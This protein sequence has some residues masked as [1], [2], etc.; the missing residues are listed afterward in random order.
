MGCT[1]SRKSLVSAL[2]GGSDA[3][4][5]AREIKRAEGVRYRY[6]TAGF[7]AKYEILDSVMLRMGMLAA[8][9]ARLHPG[10]AIGIMVTASHN[11]ECDN[12]VKIADFDGG[13]LNPEWESLASTLANCSEEK[14]IATLST[15]ARDAG[16]SFEDS[17]ALVFVGE[18]TRASSPHLASLV[19]KGAGV[20]GATVKRY[21]GCTTPQLHYL[22]WQCNVQQNPS[23][24]IKGY[25][26]DLTDAFLFLCEGLGQDK[27]YIPSLRVDCAN[28]VGARALKDIKG[29][30]S[31]HLKLDGFNTDT[32]S[33]G[34]LNEN[35]GAEY[36]QK[37]RLLPEGVEAK[38]HH[39]MAHCS[40]DGDADRIVFFVPDQKSKEGLKLMDGDKIASLL[41]VVISDLLKK[42]NLLSCLKLGV[43]QTAYAN[44]ASTEY[45]VKKLGEKY[46]LFAKTGVKHL[47]HK[48]LELD[49]GVYFEANGHGTI[50][51]SK[52]ALNEIHTKSKTQWY[53]E[54]G[55]A[56]SRLK[57]LV[58]LVN[59]AIGDA[60][61]DLL[62]VVFALRYQ[63]WT[64]DAWNAIYNDFPSTMLKVKVRDRTLVKT[65]N[66]ERECTAPE[67]LQK[68]IDELVSAAGS[69]ARAFVRPSGTEDVVR[70]YAEASTQEAASK[71]AE[72]VKATVEKILS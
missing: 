10:K 23:A 61:S 42:A 57:L 65:K 55:R 56:R 6:G 40:F 48:A 62:A 35:C 68:Q 50:L 17:S 8:L 60:M 45:L 5:I 14:V 1:S 2:R 67:G 43:V 32:E 52:K 4:L 19:E 33:K 24:E 21:V 63:K 20:L 49:V 31:K 46:V 34:K 69:G 28:G 30:I 13:M 25:F 18:D 70:V 58:Q 47:H 72:D 3:D 11:K 26:S 16:I 9:R 12:G 37:K 39:N 53:G 27:S 22:V 54:E 59:Q 15:I 38:M 7:R 41:V 29:L 36:V 71:L 44:G 64:M 51:F 66:A